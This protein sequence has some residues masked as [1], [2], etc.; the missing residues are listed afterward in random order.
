MEE[1]VQSLLVHQKNSHQ[2]TIKYFSP[3]VYEMDSQFVSSEPV[4][5]QLKINLSV[6]VYLFSFYQ[7]IFKC[8]KLLMIKRVFLFT[9]DLSFKNFLLALCRITSKDCGSTFCKTR[10]NRWARLNMCAC[11]CVCVCVRVSVC[12]WAR[13]NMCARVCVQARTE[14]ALC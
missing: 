5:C 12:V 1:E 2:S 11:V 14:P 7:Y 9:K 6:K 10:R 3:H 8:L 4:V 13:L